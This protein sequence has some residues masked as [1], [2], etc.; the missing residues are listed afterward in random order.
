[1]L[2]KMF[3]FLID[4]VRWF[5]AEPTSGSLSSSSLHSVVIFSL[6]SLTTK[7]RSSSMPA[8]HGHL[9]PMDSRAGK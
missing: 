4:L 1:M 7:L 8:F 5:S 3:F 9:D 2:P 6:A